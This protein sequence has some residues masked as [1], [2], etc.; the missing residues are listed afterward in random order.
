[1]AKLYFYYS[2]MNAGKSTILL[3]SN[4]NYQERGM[5]TLILTPNIDD[6]FESGFVHSRIGLQSPAISFESKDNLFNIIQ[7]E[8]AKSKLSCIF[9]DEAQFLNKQQV[10]EL[11]DVV[12]E[13]DIPVL[14]YGLRNDFQAEPFEGSIYLLTWADELA[15]VKTVCHCGRKANHVVRLNEQGEVVQKG[16]Q[17]EIGGNDKYESLCRR[18]FKIA[19][20]AVLNPEIQKTAS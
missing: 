1:M 10:Y 16:Q 4:H 6:R 20:N 5:N 13:L 2:T 7:A 3:Q 9:V 17:V 14:C 8:N 11:S 15:E 18:H 12:D 19:F